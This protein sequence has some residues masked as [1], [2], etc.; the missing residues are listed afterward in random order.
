LALLA[1]SG[2]ALEIEYISSENLNV[3]FFLLKQGS[4]MFTMSQA[5]VFQG[6]FPTEADLL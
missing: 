6:R 2:F 3:S 5:M 4:A 1:G